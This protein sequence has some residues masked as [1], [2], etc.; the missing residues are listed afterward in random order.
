MKKQKKQKQAIP[1]NKNKQKP[2]IKNNR[3]KHIALSIFF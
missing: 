2:A 3:T 1:P